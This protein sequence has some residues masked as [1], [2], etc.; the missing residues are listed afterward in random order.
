MAKGLD[1]KE[2]RLSIREEVKLAMREVM[3]DLSI[4]YAQGAGTFLDTV[5]TSAARVADAFDQYYTRNLEKDRPQAAAAFLELRLRA[6]RTA[7]KELQSKLTELEKRHT[8]LNAQLRAEG[9]Q[10]GRRRPKRK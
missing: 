7:E 9:A 2:V 3:D 5:I 4:T 8:R 6:G 10:K 1:Q